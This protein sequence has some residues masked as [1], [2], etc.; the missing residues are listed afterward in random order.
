MS[1][2]PCMKHM[3]GMP[4]RRILAL[5]QSN[6]NLTLH[7]PVAP[8]EVSCSPI[9]CLF[10]THVIWIVIITLFL[11]L[12]WIFIQHRRLTKLSAKHR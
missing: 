9:A 4:R 10:P 1:D 3:F 11:V 12:V 7:S 2:T 5:G 6:V 8:Q